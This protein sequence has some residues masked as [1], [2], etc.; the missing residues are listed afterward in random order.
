[1]LSEQTV[2]RVRCEACPIEF[3]ARQYIDLRADGWNGVHTFQQ[4]EFN[5]GQVIVCR[6][7]FRP[8]VES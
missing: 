8:V 5:D 3:G 2:E 1:M 7:K 6:G 4:D